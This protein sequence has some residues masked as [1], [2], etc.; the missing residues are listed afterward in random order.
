[1]AIEL[2]A[3]RHALDISE[4]APPHLAVHSQAVNCGR[5]GGLQKFRPTARDASENPTHLELHLPLGD[6]DG[7]SRG[8][9]GTTGLCG[10][11]RPLSESRHPRG[12]RPATEKLEPERRSVAFSR[13]QLAST[14]HL[15]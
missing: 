8:R 14:G 1:M 9:L 4:A 11:A 2:A 15:R 13:W 7:A 12:Q 3:R 6:P 10:H 5:G